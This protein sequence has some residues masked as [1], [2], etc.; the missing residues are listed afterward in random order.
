MLRDLRSSG[1]DWEPIQATTQ[2]GWVWLEPTS[3]PPRVV[4]GVDSQTQF[5]IFYD[6]IEGSKIDIA[7][8]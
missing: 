3:E 8:N 7:M 2:E 5:V 1:W 4:A 6:M